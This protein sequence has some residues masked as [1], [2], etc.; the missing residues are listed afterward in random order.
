MDGNPHFLF[1]LAADLAFAAIFRKSFLM[2]ASSLRVGTFSKSLFL[3]SS[4]GG[5]L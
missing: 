4:I 5:V 3:P 1:G 2:E